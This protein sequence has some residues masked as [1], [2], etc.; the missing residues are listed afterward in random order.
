MAMSLHISYMRTFDSRLSGYHGGGRRSD[1]S[2]VD[3]LFTDKSD[4]QG[5]VGASHLHGLQ[6]AQWQKRV[7]FN[8][9]RKTGLDP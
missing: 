8:L 1:L 5:Q 6:K 7:S 9:P 4:S 2:R 3:L